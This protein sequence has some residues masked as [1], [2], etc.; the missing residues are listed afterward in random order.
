MMRK[1]GSQ[2]ESHDVHAT[3]VC[4]EKIEQAISSPGLFNLGRAQ[5]RLTWGKVAKSVERSNCVSVTCATNQSVR[6]RA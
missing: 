6:S 3:N 1:A 4:R 2:V 5:L